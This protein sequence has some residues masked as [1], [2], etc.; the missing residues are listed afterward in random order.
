MGT[1]VFPSVVSK[2]ANIDVPVVGFAVRSLDAIL[3][4][5]TREERTRIPPVMHQMRDRLG[6]PVKPL[7]TT[8]S[9]PSASS[10]SSVAAAASAAAAKPVAPAAAGSVTAAAT[11]APAAG[12]SSSTAPSLPAASAD[13]VEPAPAPKGPRPPLLIF[14]EGCVVNQTSVIEF[15]RGAFTLGQPV[16]PVAI[17]YPHHSH[18]PSWTPDVSMPYLLFRL[19]CQVYNEITVTWLPAIEPEGSAEPSHHATEQGDVGAT[20]PASAP[21]RATGLGALTSTHPAS[22]SAG[23]GAA[24]AAP[25][26]TTAAVAGSEEVSAADAW[27]HALRVQT[28][29][30][31]ELGVTACPLSNADS[32]LYQGAIRG[33]FAPYA[34]RHMLAQPSADRGSA[35]GGFFTRVARRHTNAQIR[36]LVQL[37]RGFAAADANQDGALSRDEFVSHFA[38][39]LLEVG[40][41]ATKKHDSTN[42]SSATN[43][44]DVV[45]ADDGTGTRGHDGDASNLAVKG[46]PRPGRNGRTPLAGSS[47]SD[48]RVR[49]RLA[50]ALFSRLD[51]DGDGLL[52]WRELVLGLGVAA[53]AAGAAGAA[54]PSA[55][56]GTQAGASSGRSAGDASAATPAAAAAAA[57]GSGSARAS[58]AGRAH[59]SPGGES[60]GLGADIVGVTGESTAGHLHISAP[61]PAGAAPH[62]ATLSAPSAP[63]RGLGSPRTAAEAEQAAAEAATLDLQAELAFAVIDRQGDGHLDRA[64]V[65]WAVTALRRVRQRHA[66]RTGSH[67]RETALSSPGQA[68]PRDHHAA[69]QLT[70]TVG[71]RGS[72]ASVDEAAMASAPGAG[73]SGRAGAGSGAGS[74]ESAPRSGGSA[75][76]RPTLRRMESF[77]EITLEVDRL[78]G[79]A[80]GIPGALVPSSSD[81]PDQCALCLEG[82]KALVAFDRGA[83]EL[84]LPA[85][86]LVRQTVGFSVD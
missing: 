20:T 29:I 38:S 35:G 67:A 52:R 9:A 27:R 16:Q 24:P 60:V 34:L 14:P 2:A 6:L 69:G 3:V 42:G 49:D 78:F 33:G 39:R 17:A 81:S 79:V 15:Q 41:A 82:F 51:R 18:D 19:C 40:S 12:H 30:A 75:L 26:A 56:P 85:V 44:S 5:S 37:A 28:A 23:N 64:D 55:I 58:S 21:G 66:L 65:E 62:G 10:S 43:P 50:N 70:V 45:C 54:D 76:A 68:A 84:L 83:A 36:S 47:R 46:S 22:A 86:T 59:A 71:G 1:K 61:P 32:F 31:A 53:A 8:A 7:S 13:S 74:G 4:P 80:A 48:R 73:A 72:T 25:A 77:T 63:G 57:A 11:D